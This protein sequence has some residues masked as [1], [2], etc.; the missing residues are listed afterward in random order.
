MKAA[1]VLVL[2]NSGKEKISRIYT[3]PLKM[4]EYMAAGVPIVASDLP[5]IR[6]VLS[7]KTAFLFE[8]DDARDLAEKIEMV[9][10]NKEGAGER[11]RKALKEVKKYNWEER[12]G[13]I[14]DFVKGKIS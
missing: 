9:L 14:L 10:E 12:A 6:E 13:K 1:D 8:A 3:S 7:E 5:S 11:A 2:P 4:F